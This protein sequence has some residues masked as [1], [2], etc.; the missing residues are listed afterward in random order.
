MV[1]GYAQ[2]VRVNFKKKSKVEVLF[3]KIHVVEGCFVVGEEAVENQQDGP[4]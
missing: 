2:I 4:L 1:C 3:W